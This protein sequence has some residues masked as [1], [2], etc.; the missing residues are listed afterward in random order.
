MVLPFKLRTLIRICIEV[1]K[2]KVISK[3]MLSKEFE[4]TVGLNQGNALSPI[5]FNVILDMVLIAY[6][7]NIKELTSEN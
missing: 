5:L 7:V 6:I 4:I 3:Q 1:A 2:V